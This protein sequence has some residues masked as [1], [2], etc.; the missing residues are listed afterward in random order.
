M[1]WVANE[2]VPCEVKKESLTFSTLSAWACTARAYMSNG[3]LE[4]FFRWTSLRLLTDGDDAARLKVE[5]QCCSWL[6]LQL[7]VVL[8]D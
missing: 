5:R 1:L 3:L 8:Q 7:D 6:G 4:D 2:V